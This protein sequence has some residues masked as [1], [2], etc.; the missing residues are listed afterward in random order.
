M[1]PK[2][3]GDALP[4][5][6]IALIAAWI[7]QGAKLDKGIDPKADL[8]RELRK[9]WEPPTPPKEFKFPVV[10]NSVV[11]TPDNKQLVVGGYH[12]L[13]IR[14][15]ATGKLEQRIRV[16]AERAYAMLFLPDGKLAVA[17]GRPGQEGDVRIYDIAAGTDGVHDKKVLIKEL[18]Q[19]DDSQ[20]ALALSA[21]GKK[22]AAAGCDR[23]LRVWDLASGKLEQSIENHADWVMG[24]AF[25]PDGKYLL[26]AS[27]D[28][29][30][31]IWD[32]AAKESLATF[33]D[34]QNYV[35]GVAMT[36][37][38]KHGISVGEDAQIR[39][40]QATD[41]NNQIG[42]QTKTIGG[43]SKAVFRIAM[44]TA[45]KSPLIAT[46]SADGTV[47]LGDPV[48]GNSKTSLTG[49]G[50]WAYAVA[51]S[52]DGK[53]VAGGAWNGEVRIWKTE[54]GKE[55]AAFNASPGYVPIKTAEVKKK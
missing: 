34:H 2:E 45:G 11:F 37:D 7:D 38:G 55:A 52:P 8:L 51:I 24:L 50:D 20:M 14:D 36:P 16:R 23:I 13:T 12:E 4:K 6:K 27:R 53:L 31:K 22:L 35:Y 25:S 18:V 47:R 44:N 39:I 43:H 41:A 48:A 10:V 5:E 33:S 15:V 30:A 54:D 17:G 49:L 1:P 40:W 29:T 32:L 9:R 42:K 21:D 28:K 46:S 3:A 19:T 26:S